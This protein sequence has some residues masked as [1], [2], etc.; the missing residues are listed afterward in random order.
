MQLRRLEAARDIATILAASGNSVMLD[1]ATLLL[2][3]KPLRIPTL[4]PIDAFRSNGTRKGFV[5][6]EEV[7]C[8]LMEWCDPVCLMQRPR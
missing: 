1:S 8:G 6:F 3:G 7:V 5:K 4:S 2:N